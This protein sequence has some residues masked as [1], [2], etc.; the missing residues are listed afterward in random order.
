[1][2]TINI[3]N[4]LIEAEQTEE[5]LVILY[6][7]F[8][9]TRSVSGT[10]VFFRDDFFLLKVQFVHHKDTYYTIFINVKDVL[11]IV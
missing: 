6:K 4:K 5:E 11:S 2:N 7:Q 9:I 3:V 10:V 1:M 8:G